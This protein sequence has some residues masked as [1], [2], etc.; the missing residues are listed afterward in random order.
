MSTR[1]V[2]LKPE[3]CEDVHFLVHIMELHL[4]SNAEEPLSSH[5][6]HKELRGLFSEKIFPPLKEISSVGD[7]FT[8]EDF[9]RLVSGLTAARNANM[10]LLNY[11][12]E[13]GSEAEPELSF[14]FCFFRRVIGELD[15][16][17]GWIY[18]V[19]HYSAEVDPD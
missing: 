2:E 6:L 11:L 7:F 1:V 14:E 3:Q 9:S 12:T 13:R 18:D 8:E 15:D 10:G 4:D 17:T 19:F 5:P 16:L